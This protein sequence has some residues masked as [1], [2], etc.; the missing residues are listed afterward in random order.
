[1]IHVVIM[2]SGFSRRMGTDKLLLN[3]GGKPVI[4]WVIEAAMQAGANGITLVYRNPLLL[5]VAEACGILALYNPHA[6]QGQSAGIRLALSHRPEGEACLFLAGDQPLIS[7]VSLQHI[8]AVYRQEKPDIVSAVWKGKGTLPA[9]F[10]PGM[11]GPLNALTGDRGGRSLIDSGLY[12]VI[13]QDL[14]SEQ[15]QWD[16]DTPEALKELEKWLDA[17]MGTGCRNNV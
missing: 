11:R 14:C 4:R 5:P 7:P 3:L 2:A 1:M 12:A 15:E 17:G 9:L 13:Y 8:L 16:I 6:D 10:G